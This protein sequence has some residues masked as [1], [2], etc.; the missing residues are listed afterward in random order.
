M[1]KF[2]HSS[3]GGEHRP[4]SLP[5]FSLFVVPRTCLDGFSKRYE[6]HGIKC[7]YPHIYSSPNYSRSRSNLDVG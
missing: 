5:F 3:P 1:K 4:F 7:L 2:Y 6:L